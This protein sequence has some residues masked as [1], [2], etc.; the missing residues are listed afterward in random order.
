MSQV[1][2]EFQYGALAT[3][4]VVAALLFA[5]YYRK[6]GDRFFVFMATTFL[7][8]AGNWIALVGHDNEEHAF[9]V[10]LPRLAGFLTLLAGIYDKN[11]RAAT[12]ARADQ[13]DD[14]ASS[15]SS[16]K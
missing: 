9:F 3:L 6:T 8:L 5:R 13:R 15:Q 16:S 11:R 12:A 14:V 1:A 7:F 10:Y 4:A 2:F